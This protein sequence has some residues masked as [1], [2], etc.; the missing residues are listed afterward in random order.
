VR[1]IK[2]AW[3]FYVLFS[4]SPSMNFHVF[5]SENPFEFL[6]LRRLRNVSFYYELA[7]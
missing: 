3:S 7:I 2:V 5:L 4:I 1:Q 6:R